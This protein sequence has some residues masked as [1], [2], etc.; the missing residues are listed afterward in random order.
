MNSRSVSQKISYNYGTVPYELL[1]SLAVFKLVQHQIHSAYPD[2]I[3]HTAAQQRGTRLGDFLFQALPVYL[4]SDSTALAVGHCLQILENLP[5]YFLAQAIFKD[6]Q[7]DECVPH[8]P[9]HV[10]GI[11]NATD[12]RAVLL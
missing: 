6:F 4:C 9:G 5:F 10:A 12:R 8:Q 2:R 11:E 7:I 1:C 3:R